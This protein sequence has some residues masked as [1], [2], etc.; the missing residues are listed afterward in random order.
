VTTTQAATPAETLAERLR[1]L[2]DEAFAGRRVTQAQ[3][4]RAL[5]VQTSSVSSWENAVGSIVPLARLVSYA[6]FFATER[7]VEHED[8][9]RLLEDSELTDEERER[10]EQ[11]RT[12]LT[13]LHA[14]A[15][16]KRS[17]W[18]FGDGAPIVVVC[19]E[20]PE[21]ERGA[22]TSPKDKNYVGARRLGDLDALLD[23]T[24]HLKL[25]NPNSSIRIKAAPH[26]QREDLQHHVVILGGIAF[27]ILTRNLMV[28]LPVTQHET[29]HKFDYF[30]AEGEKFE[31]KLP[32]DELLEDVGLFAR[33]PNPNNPRRS[34]TICS[35]VL[36]R[37]VRGA[38]LCFADEA[39]GE[40]NE[41]YAAER[42]GDAESWG[43]LLAVRVLSGDAVAPNLWERK[44]LYEWPH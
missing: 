36:T 34:L 35:G 22:F 29:D 25:Q 28:D 8:D 15:G 30:E 38:V 11:L 14:A 7:T 40:S 17:I 12:E 5:G 10:F 33:R 32:N 37:G 19:P 21:E 9:V 4:A 27:N 2:R 23:L 41:H 39:L 13:S 43:M 20:L 18:A 1:E 42:F 6:R 26:V 31:P 24:P 16:R 3:V 44:P